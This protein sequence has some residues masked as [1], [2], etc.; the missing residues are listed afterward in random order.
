MLAEI[1]KFKVFKHQT[2]YL[3]KKVYFIYFHLINL[4]TSTVGITNGV[5]GV[6]SCK[7]T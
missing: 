3:D 1:F 2:K 5:K 6:A 7:T 4:E